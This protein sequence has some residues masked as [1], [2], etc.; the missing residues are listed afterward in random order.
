MGFNAK[1][2]DENKKRIVRIN[3]LLATFSRGAGLSVIVP[4]LYFKTYFWALIL[5]YEENYTMFV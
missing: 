2:F 4:P 3:T 5:Q 1:G